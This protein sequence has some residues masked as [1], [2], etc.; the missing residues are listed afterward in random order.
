MSICNN[1]FRLTQAW[2]AVKISS[3][4]RKVSIC[5]SS[6]CSCSAKATRSSLRW[7]EHSTFELP[8]PGWNHKINSVSE[9]FLGLHKLLRYLVKNIVS[10]CLNVCV[11]ANDVRQSPLFYLVQHS[12]S[13][14]PNNNDKDLLKHFSQRQNTLYPAQQCDDR[15]T[16]LRPSG[17]WTEQ[18]LSLASWSKMGRYLT[19]NYASK[20]RSYNAT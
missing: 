2:I 18:K 7:A 9:K 16:D 14:W 15:R 1:L 8:G 5:Q 20:G 12:P 3:S 13:E 6:A 17:I 11:F 19:T 4:T 10:N